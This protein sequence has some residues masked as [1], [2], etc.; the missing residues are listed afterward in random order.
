MP[1]DTGEITVTTYLLAY[2]RGFVEGVIESKGTITDSDITKA[3][4]RAVDR[5]LDLTKATKEQREFAY[6]LADKLSIQLAM[7]KYHEQP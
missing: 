4:R 7:E 2:S 6:I 5:V 3:F 1:E